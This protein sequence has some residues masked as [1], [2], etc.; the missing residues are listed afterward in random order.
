MFTLKLIGE[1]SSSASDS[2]VYVIGLR[3]LYITRSF[4]LNL[5]FWVISDL[6]LVI[7]L[8]C[9]FLVNL[10]AEYQ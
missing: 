6:L 7:L 2:W 4:C 10:C 1:H 9:S 5:L 3:I 8:P